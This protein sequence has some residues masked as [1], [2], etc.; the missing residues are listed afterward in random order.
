[1]S[2]KARSL[3]DIMAV[4]HVVGARYHT[5]QNPQKVLRS[6]TKPPS[7]DPNTAIMPVAAQGTSYRS[8]L[9]RSRCSSGHYRRP[10][11]QE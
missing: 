6:A 1:M 11:R 3:K 9:A 8:P 7:C 2:P 10:Y 5:L 4:H